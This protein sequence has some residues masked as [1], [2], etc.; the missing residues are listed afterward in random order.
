[1]DQRKIVDLAPDLGVT[2]ILNFS[3]F[4]TDLACQILQVKVISET[5]SEEMDDSLAN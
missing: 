5:F 4:F 2:Y 3:G 1:L